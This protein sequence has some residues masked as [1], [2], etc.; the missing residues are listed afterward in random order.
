MTGAVAGVPQPFTYSINGADGIAI[1]DEDN[2]WVAANQADEIVVVD[3]TGKAIA[4]LG[5][6]EGLKDGVTRG[7]LFPRAPT[8]ARTGNGS[9]SRTWSWI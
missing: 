1:D 5:D 4:K 8:S 6:F 2:I 3:P 7:L 9:T